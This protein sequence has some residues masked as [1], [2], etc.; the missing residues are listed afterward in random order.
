MMNELVFPE[1]SIPA[2]EKRTISEEAYLAWL[3]EERARLIREGAL[4]KLQSDV[5]RRPVD[6]RFV[7]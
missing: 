3:S 6:V 4:D 2:S 1:W 7:W 5:A